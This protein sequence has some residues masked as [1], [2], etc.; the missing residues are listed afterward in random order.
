MDVSLISLVV[1]SIIT[2]MYFSFIKPELTIEILSQ[3][4]ELNNYYSSTY[5]TLALYLGLILVT[6][7]GLNI[8]YLATKCGGSMSKNTLVALIYTFI[9]WLLMFGVLIAVLLIFPGFKSVFS[10][11]IGYYVV[12][13]SANEIFSKILMDN[14]ISEAMKNSS[15][16]SQA[17]MQSAAGLIMKM[18][19]NKSVLIN[20]LNPENFMTIW[21]TLKPLMVG[22]YN[23]DNNDDTK[24][25]KQELLNLVILKDNIGEGFWYIYTGILISSIVYYNLSSNGCV[26]DVATL[27]KE[28]EDYVKKQEEIEAQK[29]K[30][31]EVTYTM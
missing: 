13:S 19:G 9:P 21:D 26:K 3:Q 14:S 29:A 5:S 31:N 27:K 28:Q 11:V 17:E 10:D 2:F 18:V 7:L 25:I 12:Y 1:F 22:N 6:Q 30:M 8:S 24:N 23:N 20:E 16:T 4:N 15:E